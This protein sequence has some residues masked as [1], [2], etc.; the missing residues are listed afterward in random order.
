MKIIL[1]L[2]VVFTINKTAL[3]Q[4]P[5]KVLARVRYTYI[6]QK[7]TLKNG[8]TRLENMVLFT[9]KNA[10][11]FTSYDQLKHQIALDQ[12]II[13]IGKNMI[14]DGKQK[15]IRIDLS[16]NKWM[17]TTNHLY[18]FNEKKHYIKEMISDQGYLIEEIVPSLNW[19]ILKDTLSFSGVHGQKAIVSY[20]GKN[21]IAWF[22]PNLPFQSGPWELNGLPGLIIDAY[23]EQKNIHFQFAGIENANEGDFKRTTDVNKGLHADPDLINS[24]D[25]LIGFDVANAYFHNIIKLPS[26]ATKTTKQQLKKFKTALE[27]DQTQ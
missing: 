11:L 3:A 21:W 20:E 27:K 13:N 12:K 15:I 8:K 10:S 24:I 14:D 9:G 17:S 6:N 7:D 26:H 1:A 22:A 5:D 16:A 18:F 2:F 19:K 4:T 23:D 25:I